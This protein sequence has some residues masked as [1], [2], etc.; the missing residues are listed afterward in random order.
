MC[1]TFFKLFCT[2]GHTLEKIQKIAHFYTNLLWERLP[3]RISMV[4]VFGIGEAVLMLFEH[5]KKPVNTEYLY[6]PFFVQKKILNFD[7]ALAKNALGKKILK[8][9]K[10]FEILV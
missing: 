7:Q 2:L 4:N 5:L 8:K 9:K 1:P 3:K 10:K 6:F